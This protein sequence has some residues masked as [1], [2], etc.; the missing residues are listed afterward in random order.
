VRVRYEV[1]CGGRLLKVTEQLDV[2]PDPHAEAD[3]TSFTDGQH[4]W[5]AD[6]QRVAVDVARAMRADLCG[7]CGHNLRDAHSDNRENCSRCPDGLCYD[8][9][10]GVPS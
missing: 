6:E 8:C 1:F 3:G 7:R 4:W 9:R 5:V 2:T 10:T